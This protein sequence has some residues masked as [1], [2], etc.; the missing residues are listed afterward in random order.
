MRDTAPAP[1]EL[2]RSFTGGDRSPRRLLADIGNRAA[3]LISLVVGVAFAPIN[4]AISLGL[5]LWPL[6]LGVYAAVIAYESWSA[7]LLGAACL[8]AIAV[9]GCVMLQHV[10]A[11]YATWFL[12]GA[13]CYVR[14]LWHNLEAVVFGTPFRE[15]E[16]DEALCPF[17]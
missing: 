16:E 17:R 6:V 7:G 12:H 14:H 11:R 2:R 5:A 1:S 15:M 9:A 3:A 13:L 4:L 8:S 10:Y